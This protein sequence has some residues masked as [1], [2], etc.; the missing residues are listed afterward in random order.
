MRR[1]VIRRAEE[2]CEYCGLAQAGPEAQF[3]LDHIEPTS[4]GG[5]D[6]PHNL[7]LACVSC[8]LRKGARRTVRDPLSAAE[9]RMFNPRQHAR[10]E[11]FR[12]EGL[13]LIG[14][15]EIGRGMVE[16][17]QLNRTLI[18]AIRQEEALRLRHPPP[19]RA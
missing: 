10:Q 6:E 14:R 5:A 7:A 15:T 13:R 9:V 19:V 11:H 16:A 17:L 4:A 2:R 12:W 3:H 18:V 1:L 8:S